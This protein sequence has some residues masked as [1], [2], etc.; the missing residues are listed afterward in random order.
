MK[1]NKLRKEDVIE[2]KKLMQET[3]QYGFESYTKQKEEQVL[4]EKDIDDC[5]NNPNGHAYE[6]ID[7]DGSIL[8]GTIVNINSSTQINHLDF[9]FVRVGTQSKGIGQAIW[10]EIE[11]L[12]SKTKRWITC[13]PYFDVRNIHFYVN[14]L[15][16]H[17]IEFWNKYH[18][19]SNKPEDFIGDNFEGMFEF[20]K[21]MKKKF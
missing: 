4:P 9:L 19:D 5:L 18:P 21:V 1:L 7:D 3:F 12:C 13:T 11:S 8:G 15:K 6:M 14:K 16:F 10:K 2:F 17:I 20:E